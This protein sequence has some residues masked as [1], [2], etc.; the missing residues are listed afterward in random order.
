MFKVVKDTATPAMKRLAKRLSP[1]E[2]KRT[3]LQ[4]GAMIRL[5]AQ[6]TALSKGGRKFWREMARSVGV[7]EVSAEAVQVYS[8]HVAA[9]QMQ[10]GGRISAPG[11]HSESPA[12]ALT[13]PFPGSEA[14]GRRASEFTQD[15]F[16]P[17]GTSVL[18]YSDDGEFVPLFILRKSV[19]GHKDP[20]WPEERDVARMGERLA[21]RRLTA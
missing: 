3:L 8:N 12:K 7:R 2:R 15:L 4:W 1:P 17:K 14:E 19:E 16:V 10:Y 5:K 6:E 13:I 18:G 20:W 9:A 11:K 21:L